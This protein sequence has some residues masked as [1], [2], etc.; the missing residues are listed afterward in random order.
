MIK[1]V[2]LSQCKTSVI[3]VTFILHLNFRD[4][5]SKYSPNCTEHIV[6]LNALRGVTFDTAHKDEVAICICSNDL[7]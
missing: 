4:R 5:F 7:L 1:N 2:H 6:T 3:N